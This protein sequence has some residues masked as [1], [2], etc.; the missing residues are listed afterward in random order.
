MLIRVLGK[1]QLYSLQTFFLYA[2]LLGNPDFHEYADDTEFHLSMKPEGTKQVLK[3]QM[4]PGHMKTWMNSLVLNSPQTEVT[5]V[6]VVLHQIVT[7]GITL[8]PSTTVRKGLPFNVCTKQVSS[9]FL[10]FAEYIEC[11]R[12]L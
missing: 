8:V 4:C 3:V 10:S 12:Y 1:D 9:S 5:V 7:D 2:I 11:L 6:T